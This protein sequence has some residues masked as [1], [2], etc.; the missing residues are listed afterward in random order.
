LLDPSHNVV[1]Q[2]FREEKI[3]NLLECSSEE[4]LS[5]LEKY[6]LA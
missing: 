6:G 2:R 3:G 4:R 1:P 5:F